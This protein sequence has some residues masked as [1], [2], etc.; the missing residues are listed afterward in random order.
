MT[1]SSSVALFIGVIAILVIL[2]V[3]IRIFRMNPQEATKVEGELTGFK[4]RG[5]SSSK[6]CVPVFSFQYKGRTITRASKFPDARLNVKD[7]GNTYPLLYQ[8]TL[9][10]QTLIQDKPKEIRVYKRNTWIAIICSAVP[11]AVI[12]AIVVA[13][14]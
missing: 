5:D 6:S 2:I 7:M 11:C 10:S 1:T 9:F 14:S 8:R 3:A 12:I 13:F 4:Q